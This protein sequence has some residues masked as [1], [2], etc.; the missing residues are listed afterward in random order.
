MVKNQALEKFVKSVAELT[1]PD[2]IVWCNGSEYEYKEIINKA[3]ADGVFIE[4]NQE[5]HPNCYLHRSDPKDVARTEHLTF[6][7]SKNKDDSG[8]TNNWI[9]PDEMKS[10]L[11]TLFKESMRGRIMYVV[12]YIMGPPGSP[13]SQ[14]GVEITDSSYVVINLRIM[15]WI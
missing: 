9:A 3:L 8:P 13:Y 7:C 6:V 12:P 4:L 15:I 10:K 2:D 11:N 5:K 1:K 14:V